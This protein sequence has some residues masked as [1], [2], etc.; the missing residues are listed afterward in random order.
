MARNVY[1]NVMSVHC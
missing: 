1:L